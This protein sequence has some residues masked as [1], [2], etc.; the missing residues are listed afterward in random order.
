M[1]LAGKLKASL[2]L[3][4]LARTACGLSVCRQGGAPRLA[5]HLIVF[6]IFHTP[7]LFHRHHSWSSIITAAV[8]SPVKHTSRPAAPLG[9][10]PKLPISLSSP[11]W[12]IKPSCFNG[13]GRAQL[14]CLQVLE[15]LLI[16]QP[17]PSQ[18]SGLTLLVF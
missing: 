7:H 12:P 9:Q 10:T 17:L 2:C 11:Q 1:R 15:T 6:S 5:Q 8:V 4:N 16:F 18:A 13:W 14:C 3:L